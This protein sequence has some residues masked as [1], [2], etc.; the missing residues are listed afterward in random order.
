M[1]YR[2]W[3]ST[4]AYALAAQA[5]SVAELPKVGDS[6][7]MWPTDLQPYPDAVFFLKVSE[8]ERIK[9]HAQRNTTDTSE[10]IRLAKD[11]KFRGV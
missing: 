10:E 8:A 9:R 2:F 6:I 11:E 4:A 7:Y 3:H 1:T 5:E